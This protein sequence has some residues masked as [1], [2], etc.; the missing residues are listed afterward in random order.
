MWSLRSY[1]H[2]GLQP[3]IKSDLL[4]L[5]ASWVRELVRCTT[6]PLYVRMLSSTFQSQNLDGLWLTFRMDPSRIQWIKLTMTSQYWGFHVVAT[7]IQ[8][9]SKAVTY[10]WSARY[11]IQYPT[12]SIVKNWT[13][14]FSTAKFVPCTFLPLLV[15]Y[16]YTK[17]KVYDY[18]RIN[19][20]TISELY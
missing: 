5:A 16:V 17:I 8:S 3:G 4:L 15:R 20:T 1:C 2:T 9:F 19:S 6:Q 10:S 7:V 14:F 13:L 18:F 11:V 12:L